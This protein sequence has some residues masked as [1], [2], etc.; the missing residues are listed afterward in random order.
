MTSRAQLVVR[1]VLLEP[2][3]E[4]SGLEIV[5]ATGLAAGRAY[6]IITRL[7]QRGR[8]S[9]G[10]EDPAGHADD[11]P[12]RRRYRF[13]ADG[14]EEAWMALAEARRSRRLAPVPWTG[15]G[16]RAPGSAADAARYA[17]NAVT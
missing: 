13:T 14:A 3:R 12:R 2:G 15:P 7:D 8:L 16:A 17:M 4:W 10:W 1:R 5:R 6:P 11:L 9:L